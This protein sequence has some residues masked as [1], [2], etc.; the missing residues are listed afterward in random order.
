MNRFVISET[1]W[2]EMLQMLEFHFKKEDLEISAARIRWIPN[3]PLPMPSRETV[4][5]PLKK[6]AG[7]TLIEMVMVIVLLGV[8]A[9]VALPRFVSLQTDSRAAVMR[10]ISGNA[11]SAFAG[12]FAK[13]AVQGVQAQPSASV[14]INGTT[15]QLKYGYPALLSVMDVLQIDPLSNFSLIPLSAS[16]GYIAPSGV[17]NDATCRVVFT[18]AAGAGSAATVQSFLSGC[19]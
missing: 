14:V 12:V 1:D 16:S 13:A 18:E 9:A 3:H 2:N 6:R 17:A 10:A 4:K 7:F 11:S 8:L 19:S 5:Y 15:I